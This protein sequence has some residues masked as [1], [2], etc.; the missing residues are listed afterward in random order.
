MSLM[1]GHFSAE[2]RL[3]DEQLFRDHL[4]TLSAFGYLVMPQS[5]L[6]GS[7]TAMQKLLDEMKKAAGSLEALKGEIT[8]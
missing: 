6:D 2:E 4:D 5:A 1:N 3:K 8:G 7:I